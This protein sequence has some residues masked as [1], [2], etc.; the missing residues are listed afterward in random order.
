[1]GPQAWEQCYVSLLE[2][3]DIWQFY[4]ISCYGWKN[5]RNGL[6]S[7][8]DSSYY[9]PIHCELTH[10]IFNGSANS[11]LYSPWHSG[12]EVPGHSQRNF[13]NSAHCKSLKYFSPCISSYRSV[14]ISW[15]KL[16]CYFQHSL[17]FTSPVVFY[18][19]QQLTSD[20]PVFVSSH[21]SFPSPHFIFSPIL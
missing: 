21:S 20:L 8:A 11:K 16:P 10:R 17:T 4:T 2:A 7:L 9:I 18:P 14:Y 5:N 6:H 1:M 15:N 13:V 19:W 12:Q 3:K